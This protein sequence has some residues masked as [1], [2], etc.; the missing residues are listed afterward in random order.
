MAI[1][2]YKKP[3]LVK[4]SNGITVGDAEFSVSSDW[5]T[6]YYTTKSASG[7]YDRERY[8]TEENYDLVLILDNN[9]ITKQINEGSIFLI[10]EYP[11]ELNV[12]GNYKAKK[13]SF[14]DS[15]KIIVMLNAKKG[16]KHRNL[17]F[18][19]NDQLCSIQC[20]YDSQTNKGYFRK[21]ETI[22]FTGNDT[23]WN[24]E[25][26]TNED[27]EG[28][29]ILVSQDNVGIVNDLKVFIELTFKEYNA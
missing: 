23:I 22:P 4:F 16:V 1:S 24:I 7:G 8:G 15:G 9:N 11:T 21:Y 29:I 26:L 20:N 10:D 12:E 19:K 18:L 13:I 14:T 2:R 3:C 5:T 6:I 25:P 17:Y 27:S 28:R